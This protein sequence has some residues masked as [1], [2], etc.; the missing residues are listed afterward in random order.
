MRHMSRRAFT[1]IELLVVV[2]IVALLIAILLPSLGRAKML[3][4]RTKCGANLAGIGKAIATYS[5]DS[6]NNA[7]DLSQRGAYRWSGWSG[8]QTMYVRSDLSWGHIPGLLGPYLGGARSKM[9]VCPAVPAK[10]PLDVK[11]AAGNEWW[12][13]QAN[14]VLSGSPTMWVRGT[15]MFFV[16]DEGN[17]TGGGS[18]PEGR[19]GW[20]DA[21]AYF[22][23]DGS[24]PYNGIYV[25]RKL[26]NINSEQVYVQDLLQIE[27]ASGTPMGNH[28]ERGG[29]FVDAF[30]YTSGKRNY[31]DAP[32]W[33]TAE[34]SGLSGANAL[35][36]S[37]AVEWRSRAQLTEVVADSQA[38]R[39]FLAFPKY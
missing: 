9:L 19:N 21:V 31:I 7:A 5:S 23:K 36:A 34:I 10:N 30:S 4:I 24:T 38:K 6:S 13:D 16:G 32:Y 39:F 22:Q 27:E 15:Y 14:K 37:G 20:H 12:D 1:L 8:N 2:A 28:P 11:T 29:S 26:L 3:S 18:N 33:R 35:F 17:G 25:P